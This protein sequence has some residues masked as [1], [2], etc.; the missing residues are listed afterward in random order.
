MDENGLRGEIWAV[1]VNFTV[2]STLMVLE[3]SRHGEIN[4][5]VGINRED[6][7]GPS[8]K[9]NQFRVIA[10]YNSVFP[11]VSPLFAQT[12]KNESLSQLRQVPSFIQYVQPLQKSRVTG[13]KL[14]DFHSEHWAQ[15]GEVYS[16]TDSKIK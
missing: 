15:A 11:A 8:P 6:G 4:Q 9:A 5:Q 3:T 14:D 1:D 12:A 2:I 7:P 13:A 16:K 10:T